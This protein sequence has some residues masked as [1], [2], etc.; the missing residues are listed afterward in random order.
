MVALVALAS[1]NSQGAQESL[2]C[3]SQQKVC[4]LYGCDTVTNRIT[5]HFDIEKKAGAF[6]HIQGQQLGFVEAYDVVD[7]SEDLATG[8]QIMTANGKNGRSSIFILNGLK[9]TLK[10]TEGIIPLKCQ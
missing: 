3:Y 9:S 5:G 10:T 4:G 1:M 2:D 6:A 8:E 7:F